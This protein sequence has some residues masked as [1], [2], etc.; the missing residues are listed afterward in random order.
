MEAWYFTSLPIASLPGAATAKV[1]APARIPTGGQFSSGGGS[2]DTIGGCCSSDLPPKRLLKRSV[3]DCDAAGVA[4]M[5][6]PIA[7]ASTPVVAV[8]RLLLPI[9]DDS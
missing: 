1:D 8:L 3:S 9:V 5:T 6:A 2:P 7:S 4:Q